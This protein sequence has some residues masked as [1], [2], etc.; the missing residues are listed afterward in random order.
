M[1]FYWGR[2]SK[3]NRTGIGARD[4]TES[5]P[6]SRRYP[7]RRGKSGAAHGPT[8]IYKVMGSLL[9]WQP[10]MLQRPRANF[11]PNRPAK[12]TNLLAVIDSLG[13]IENGLFT[14][15]A[16]VKPLAVFCEF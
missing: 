3:V 12:R 7:L 13:P 11:S 9:P 8:S 15:N 10:S 2:A 1:Q 16:T 14:D 6:S 4:V 5:G